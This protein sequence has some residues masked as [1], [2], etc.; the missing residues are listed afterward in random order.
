M[1]T[2]G[3]TPLI[4][5]I[6]PI[7]KAEKYIERCLDSIAAQTMEGVEYI[8]VDDASPDNSSAVI[9][10]FFE[11]HPL[12]GSSYRIITNPANKGV[13]YSRQN[14]LDNARGKYVIHVDPDDWL[15]PDY[16]SLL[17]RQAE[18][19]MA[20]ITF[21]DIFIEYSDRQELSRQCPALPEADAVISALCRSD[22]LGSC[23]NK[24]V[25]RSAI[26]SSGAHFLPGI[27]VCEDIVFFLQLLLHGPRISTVRRPLYH[28]D[29]FTST[30]SIQR[31]MLPD[32]LAQDNR[33]IEAVGGI[34]ADDRY[35]IPRGDFIS[36]AIFHI[37]EISG[38]SSA[39]FRRRYSF[40]RPYISANASFSR[41]KKA[42]LA[43]ACS[44]LYRPARRLYALL[45][46]IK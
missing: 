3:H 26:E 12:T 1:E 17:Y 39:E 4:S 25:R 9:R 37:F 38:Y 14:G 8:F 44:G 33:L 15:E 16:L 36:S 2:T 18:K 19:D 45:K 32:H 23:W 28:Y 31:H 13:G 42:I 30:S 7:Y 34:L 43:M 27:N 29:R 10:R 41:P 21:C 11:H 5:V 24:L 40:A 35:T 20:D 22:I 6:L 46:S